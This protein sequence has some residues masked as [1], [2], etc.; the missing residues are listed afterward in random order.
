M[1]TKLFKIAMLYLTTY[2]TATSIFAGYRSLEFWKGEIDVVAFMQ[3]FHY[4]VDN[5][6]TRDLI[7]FNIIP[8]CFL[9]FQSILFYKEGLKVK[10]F[11]TLLAIVGNAVG[12]FLIFHFAN[13]IRNE[14]LNWD[15][16]QLPS[17]WVIKKDLWLNHI[18]LSALP[19]LIGYVCF[20]TTFFL[21]PTAIAKTGKLNPI[22]NLIKNVILF[23][24]AVILAFQAAS[25][26]ESLFT[27]FDF[28]QSGIK[29]FEWHRQIHFIAQNVGKIMFPI[30]VTLYLILMVLF[31]FEGYKLKGLL[32][33]L[34]LLLLLV[35][36]YIALNLNG[37]LNDSFLIWNAQ[38]IPTNW[39]DL[40]NDWLDFHFYRNCLNF[41]GYLCFIL[42]FFIGNKSENTKIFIHP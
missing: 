18:T 6:E 38:N 14:M 26:I 4:A 24:F 3:W 13:P 42:V 11:L 27:P 19:S 17:E 22:F 34:T 30:M 2:F 5:I 23:F 28:N 21:K 41:L 29:F 20:I 25:P 12:I 33:G 36:T 40:V 16:S 7:L 1:N 8:I 31:V 9:A 15:V 32:V 10:S 37:P 35:D 39:K